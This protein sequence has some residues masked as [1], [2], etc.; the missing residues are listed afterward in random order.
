MDSSYFKVSDAQSTIRNECS[1]LST[2]MGLYTRSTLGVLLHASACFNKLEESNQI[3]TFGLK[4]A[5][6]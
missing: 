5:I 2:K 4:S 6:L 1:L 3:R